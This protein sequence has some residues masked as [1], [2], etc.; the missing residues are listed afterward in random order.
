MNAN[1]IWEYKLQQGILKEPRKPDPD[2]DRYHNRVG[3][4]ANRCLIVAFREVRQLFITSKYRDRAFVDDNNTY[5]QADLNQVRQRVGRRLR[6]EP[7]T[8]DAISCSI[9]LRPPTSKT[10]LG[11]LR[12]L[13]RVA[14]T[15]P[16]LT[17]F[18]VCTRRLCW[19][20]AP[21]GRTL[22]KITGLHWLKRFSLTL[23]WVWSFSFRMARNLT[24]LSHAAGRLSTIAYV[25]GVVVSMVQQRT[26]HGCC[27]PFCRSG[28]LQ[29]SGNR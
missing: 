26:S 5:T 18:S 19:L 16:L 8:L 24:R 4:I 27:C 9:C 21:T 15:S 3:L 2:A 22:R 6:M 23:P 13:R 12:C 14:G 28:L 1:S 11:W 7:I 10:C 17:A 29:L 25:R 20:V